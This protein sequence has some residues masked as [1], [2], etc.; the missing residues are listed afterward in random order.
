MCIFA[1]DLYEP[2]YA[3]NCYQNKGHRRDDGGD[4]VPDRSGKDGHHNR[5]GQ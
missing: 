3:N 1:A 5:Q 2:E 4:T